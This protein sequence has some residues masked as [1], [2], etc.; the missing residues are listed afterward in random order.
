M[1]RG[2]V[3]KSPTRIRIVNVYRLGD[4]MDLSADDLT[5]ESLY[6]RCHAE[7]LQKLKKAHL[8]CEYFK[9]LLNVKSVVG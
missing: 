6:N 8:D 5:G 3:Y 4:M 1:F 2:F 7:D 9:L